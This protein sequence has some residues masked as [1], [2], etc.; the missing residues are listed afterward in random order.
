MSSVEIGHASQLD[1]RVSEAVI[2]AIADLENVSP[3]EL[4]PLY[5]VIDPDALNVLFQRDATPRRVEFSY[6]GH[7]VVVRNEGDVSIDRTK[8]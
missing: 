3:L 8:K 5:E 7:D 4:P 6:R 2:S 1:E